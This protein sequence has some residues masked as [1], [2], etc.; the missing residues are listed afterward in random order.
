MCEL[1]FREDATD[2]DFKDCRDRRGPASSGARQSVSEPDR[3]TSK[4]HADSDQGPTVAPKPKLWSLA[5]IA[6]S[7][8]RNRSC[9]DSSQSPG[10]GQQQAPP[11]TS[12]ARTAFPHGAPLPRHLYYTTPFIPGYSSFSPLGPLHGGPGS[13]TH[14]NGLHQTLLQRAEVAAAAAAAAARDCRRSQSQLE[15]HELQR[16]TANV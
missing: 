8:D 16:G 13:V 11:P 10:P 6:T 2:P 5:E 9:S 4:E 12:T 15:L 1:I 7:S 14:L 3:P